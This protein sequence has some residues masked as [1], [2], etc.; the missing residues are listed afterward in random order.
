MGYIIFSAMA[1]WFGLGFGLRLRN[2]SL[3]PV[4]YSISFFAQAIHS[5][6]LGRQDRP[7]QARPGRPQ[8]DMYISPAVRKVASFV[9]SIEL[10]PAGFQSVNAAT[11]ACS[12][13]V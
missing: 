11:A 12:A 8:A 13:F 4:K 2:P 5:T 7:G 10:P 1:R 3:C 6:R 9:R